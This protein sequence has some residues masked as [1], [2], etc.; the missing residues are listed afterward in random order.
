MCGKE[1]LKITQNEYINKEDKMDSLLNFGATVIVAIIGLVGIVIQ[2]KSK[3]KQDSIS[4]K[5]DTLSTESKNADRTLSSKLDESK[6]QILKVWLT[7]ELT[8]VRDGVYKPNEE[9]KRLL[10]E[11]KKEY[12]NLGGDS[13]VNYMFDKCKEKNLI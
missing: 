4:K 5:I 1:R 8:K 6:M 7:N 11:A 9:Q 13:Y 2:T 3:E 10:F 12:N